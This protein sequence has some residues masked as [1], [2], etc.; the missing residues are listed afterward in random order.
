MYVHAV[1]Y[2]VIVFTPAMIITFMMDVLRVECSTTDPRVLTRT[3]L[4]TDRA[5]YTCN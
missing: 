3:H 4:T 1:T 5:A 2:L